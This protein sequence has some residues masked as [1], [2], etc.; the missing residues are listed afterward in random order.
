MSQ[1]NTWPGWE[2]MRELGKGSFGRVYEIQR[3]VFGNIEKAAIK[4]ISIPQ[5]QSEIA[6]LRADGYDQASI[7]KKY[8]NYLADIVKE[9]SLM[10]KLKGNSYIVDCDDLQYTPHENGIGWDIVIKMELLTPLID[11]LQNPIS[12]EQV[13]HIGKDICNALI[14]CK[15]QNIIHRDIKPQNIFIS[16]NGDYKLGDFGIAKVAESTTAGTKTGTYKYMAP[17]VYNNR[18]YGTSADLYSLGMVLYWLLNERRAP[19]LPL[20]PDRKSVV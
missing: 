10:A 2:C 13:I 9:Y 16:P 14:V 4:V 11:A 6:E 12:D 17:E 20:P 5:D 8:N 18:P 7:I 19:F 1:I 3:N 15:K